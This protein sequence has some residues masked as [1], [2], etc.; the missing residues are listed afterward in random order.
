MAVAVS[1]RARACEGK[2]GLA[3]DDEGLP[4]GGCEHHRASRRIR[5]VVVGTLHLRMVDDV[6]A[7]PARGAPLKRDDLCLKLRS[8]DQPSALRVQ[9]RQE[10]A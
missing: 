1:A 2:D 5:H 8:F 6:P 10:G 7:R 4:A 3:A 9:D